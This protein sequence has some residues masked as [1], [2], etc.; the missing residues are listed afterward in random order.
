MGTDSH[1]QPRQH[2]ADPSDPYRREAQTFPELDDDMAGRA[3]AFGSVEEWPEGGALFERGQRS[4]DFFLVLAGAVEVLDVDAKGREHVVHVH[5]ARQFTGELDLF[6]DRKILVSARALPGTRLVR[7]ERL[8]FRRL[9]AAEPDIGEVV[10]RAFILRR[11]GMM[12]HGEAGIALIGPAHGAAT[13]RIESFLRRNGLPHR[14]IDTETDADAGGFLECFRLAPED[15]PVVVVRGQ[16]L[17]RPSNGQVAD[18]LGLTVELDPAHVHDVA[19]VGAGPAGL[20]SAVYAASEGLDTIVVESIAPGGQAGT[21]SKIE[22]YLGFPTGISGQAL[23]GRAQVQA[24][25]FGA[26][27][28]VSRGAVGLDCAATPFVVRLDDGTEIR[29]RVVVVATGARYRKL[30]LPR[31]AEL[32]GNGI[33]YAATN[34]EAGLC[35]GQ[36]VVVVGGGNSA[37]QAAIYLARSAGHVHIL[38]RGKGLA[39][40]MSR[41]LID[42]IEASD[43]ITLHPFTEVTALE[44]ERHLTGLGWTDRKSGEASRRRVGALFV[45]IGAVPATDWLDGCLDLDPAGFVRT[46]S[47]DTFFC[48]SRPGIFAVGDVRSGSV[49]RV[50]SGVGEGSVVVSS[51][52]RYLESL[53]Q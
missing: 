11:V 12:L 15:L 9:I 2:A 10:M 46:G 48:S 25:K 45:M 50:A 31:Y 13:V 8:A 33:Y 41:Y 26:R 3:A 39:E 6:N 34:M 5:G 43:R 49:K 40:T 28:L 23:A 16:A 52:H 20:A 18:A 27:L 22:N 1:L 17:R 44:G 4:V 21:S 35:A 42:R 24:Q 36:E 47:G 29:S 7:V 19:V 30:D 32:E 37:G 53:R 14:Q 38:V 51:I